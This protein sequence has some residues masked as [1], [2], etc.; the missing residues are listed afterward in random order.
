MTTQKPIMPAKSPISDVE[1]KT[2]I[3]PGCAE[4]GEPWCDTHAPPEPLDI[5]EM[6]AWANAPYDAPRPDTPVD[7]VAKLVAEIVRLR[8]EVYDQAE[9]I[10]RLENAAF[11]DPMAEDL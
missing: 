9:E 11:E 6:I 1:V 7:M 2:C 4:H 8:D 5:T 10:T 3:W